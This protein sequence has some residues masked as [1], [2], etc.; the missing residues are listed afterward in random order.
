MRLKTENSS[1]IRFLKDEKF[2]EWKLFPTDELDRYW[3]E[4]LQLHPEDRTDVKLAEKHFHNINISSYALP[5]EKKQEAI[6]RME[7]S[8]RQYHRKHAIRRFVYIAAASVAILVLSV[9][10]IQKESDRFGQ[11]P[12]VDY[13]LGSELESE[14]ILFITGNRIVSFQSNVDIQINN[15]KT[16]Q[17]KSEENETEEITIEEYTLN[18]VIIPYG[19]RSKIV[20]P[21]GTRVWLNSGSS[22]EFSSTFSGDTREISLSGEIYI[23]VE[24][25]ND[26][27]FFV[28]TRGY[29][30]KVYGTKF[31]VRAYTGVPSSVVLVEGSVSLYTA[32]ERE[33]FLLPKEQAIFSEVTGIFDKEEVD[34]HSFIS[35]KDGYLTFE[36]SPV[37]E[38]LQQIERY[39][40][41]SFNLND[42]ISFKGLTCTGKI[43][44][45]DNLDNVMTALS[46]ISGTKYK[47]ENKLIYIY[48]SLPSDKNRF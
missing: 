38:V 22:L 29:D 3:E 12:S 46:L 24:P 43:I 14:D 28:H 20:L 31:N 33:L 27:P 35:W 6:E 26:K 10:F 23:E 15:D 11:A 5:R 37:I 48:K 34:V 16:A 19:K 1:F 47:R 8:L 2:I 9:L 45:S 13:I 36:D 42:D 4:Y 39:Y 32:G 30:I 7:Q 18:K 44:L 17:V 21:D 25:D 41:L 40:N